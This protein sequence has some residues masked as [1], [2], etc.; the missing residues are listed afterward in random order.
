M[1]PGYKT[2]EFWL[3]L[4]ASLLGAV[5]GAH[6]GTAGGPPLTAVTAIPVTLPVIIYALSRAWQKIAKGV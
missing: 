4:G 1:K 2:T 6:L 5:Q 3:T